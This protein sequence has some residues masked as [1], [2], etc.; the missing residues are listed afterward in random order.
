MFCLEETMMHRMSEMRKWGVRHRERMAECV[1]TPFTSALM[2]GCVRR[3]QDMLVGS[4]VELTEYPCIHIMELLALSF[5]V[6]P[7]ELNLD[8]RTS[9]VREFAECFWE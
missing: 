9:A 4:G 1:P 8:F 3:G 6:P 2:R 5:G 7:A